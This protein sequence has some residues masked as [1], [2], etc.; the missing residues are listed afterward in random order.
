MAEK[1]VGFAER[2]KQPAGEHFVL[3]EGWSVF[4]RRPIALGSLE[5]TVSRMGRSFPFGV[6]MSP[7][8][9]HDGGIM[10]LHNAA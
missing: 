5:K 8:R 9:L 2:K 10:R 7:D 3:A 1:K 6:A 4:L